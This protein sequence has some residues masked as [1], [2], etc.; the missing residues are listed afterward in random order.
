LE[1]RFGKESAGK[2]IANLIERGLLSDERYVERVIQK[3]AFEKK[4]GFLKVE[5]ELYK[6]GIYKDIFRQKLTELVTPEIER[7]IALKLL[8]KKPKDKI[9]AY[10]LSRGF[11]PHIVQEVLADKN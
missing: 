11:R 6:K 5:A 3:Y 9:R 7:E 4:Y 1:E 2:V 10:L 8:S